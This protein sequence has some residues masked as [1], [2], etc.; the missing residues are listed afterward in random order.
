L[1][2]EFYANMFQQ[3]MTPGAALRAA[4]N[5]LR[6]NSEWRSPHYWAG[7]TLQGEN[8]RV[9]GS[10]SS[11]STVSST[12]MIGVLVFMSAGALWLIRRW[13]LQKTPKSWS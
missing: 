9:L 11:G 13:K 7:F 1:M 2:K 4:Q 8:R 6:R 12:I 10:R 5:S 3:G